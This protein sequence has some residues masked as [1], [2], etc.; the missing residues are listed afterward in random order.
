MSEEYSAAGLDL[1]H[2]WFDL[3][4]SERKKAETKARVRRG[5]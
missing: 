2:A 3:K 1:M 5:R 4:A